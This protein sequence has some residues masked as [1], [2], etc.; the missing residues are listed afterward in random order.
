LGA[1]HIGSDRED[2]LN[3]ILKVPNTTSFQTGIVDGALASKKSILEDDH[4]SAQAAS[5]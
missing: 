3:F 5:G 4:K 1:F 2:F